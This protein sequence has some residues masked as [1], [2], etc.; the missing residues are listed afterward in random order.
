MLAVAKDTV[1]KIHYTLTNGAGE[2]LDSSSG[3]DPLGYLHG[4]SNI[5]PGLESQL[6]GKNV[7]DKLIANVSAADGYGVRDD[8]L[9]QEVPRAAFPE[10]PE[11]AAG[12]QFQAEGP[13]GA[14]MVTVTAV[15][16]DTVTVDGNHPLAGV[17]L[18][19]DVEIVEI[20]AA[21]EEELSHG[22]VHGPGGHHH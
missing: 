10:D 13:Q 17:D 16:A 11:P 6:E 14:Q 21:S 20:R 1:V 15:S 12:M 8:E 7:G 18:S 22:H 5:I 3:G 19:F 2:V 9:V 4:H